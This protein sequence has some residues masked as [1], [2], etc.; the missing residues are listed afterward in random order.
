MLLDPC[1]S[2]PDCLVCLS[3]MLVYCGQTVRWIKMELGMQVG[4]DPGHIL[5]DE[6]PDPPPQKGWSPQFLAH[7][8]C[9]Q[10]A[11]WIKMPLGT[12]INLVPGDFVLDGDPASPPQKGPPIFGPCLLLPNGWIDQGDTWH[13]RGPRPRRHCVR[14]E[15]PPKN[16]HSPQFSAHVYCGQTA[17]CIRIP[18]GTEVG[19]SLGDIVL[20]GDPAPPPLKGQSPPIFGQ[21]PLWPNGWMD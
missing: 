7:V 12:E 5:L 14:W 20:D 18:L 9:G 13:E 8:Y 3:M 6:D 10:T 2:Y 21:C 16:G 17:V 4:L 11:G 1:L 15:P 19:L